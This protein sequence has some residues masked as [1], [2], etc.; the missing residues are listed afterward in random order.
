MASFDKELLLTIVYCSPGCPLNL[1]CGSIINSIPESF[2]RCAS[3]WNCS[4]VNAKPTC[5]T[6][7][8]SPSTGL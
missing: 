2:K 5:G 4:I 7:T 8:S 1:K 3:S 6:G